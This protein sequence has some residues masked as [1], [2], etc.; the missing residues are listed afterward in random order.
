MKHPG[1]QRATGLNT[2]HSISEGTGG[3][4]KD[5]K[6]IQKHKEE[7]H[8][9]QMR[10]KLEW[11]RQ[12]R[13]QGLKGWERSENQTDSAFSDLQTQIHELVTQA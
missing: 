2:S 11:N 3:Q 8:R 5:T 1:A 7:K 6:I 13:R 4:D 10:R 12:I 9:V